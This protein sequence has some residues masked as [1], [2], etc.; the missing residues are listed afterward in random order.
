[1][2]T[3]KKKT[4]PPG[5][6]GEPGE[7]Y[8]ADANNREND[9]GASLPTPPELAALAAAADAQLDGI[10]A[11]PGALG[12]AVEV[13]DR[14]PELGAML[15]MLVKMAAP[16]LP[17]LPECYTDETCDRIGTA[18]DAVA[19]KYG[20]DLDAMAAPEIALALVTV[21]PTIAAWGMHKSMMTERARARM[22]PP[23][24]PTP[25]AAA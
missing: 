14:G 23:P 7:V 16:A 13:V 20:W 19:R 6:P 2:V 15:Q 1:M 3:L 11:A 18:F 8:E 12:A 4:A 5:S 21:P 10:T 24:A 25:A 17:Y 9:G 22:Q